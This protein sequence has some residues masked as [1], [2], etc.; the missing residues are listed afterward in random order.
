MKKYIVLMLLLL[1]LP[2]FLLK[3]TENETKPAKPVLRV[4]AECDYVP[5]SWE[6]T[7]ASEYNLPIANHKGYYADGYDIQI[8]KIVAGRLDYDIEIVKLAWNDL[9]PSLNSGDIDAIFSSMLDTDERKK[10]AAFSEPYEINKVEYGIIVGRESPYI[11]AKALKDFSGAKLIGERGTKL[12]DVIEQIPGAVHLQPVDSV[13]GMIDA[14]LNAEAD[15]AVIDYDTGS[16]Y[17][18][19]NKELA[20]VKFPADGGFKLGFNGVCA[21]V[22]KENGDLLHRIDIAILEIDRSTRQKTMDEVSSRMITN[23]R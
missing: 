3:K 21:A 8:A 19:M 18:V 1:L 20:L 16:Y 4:G 7:Q 13:R 6:E 9:L 22:K 10:I 2:L 14:V 17:E 12:D 11:T 23:L 15:G 5:N